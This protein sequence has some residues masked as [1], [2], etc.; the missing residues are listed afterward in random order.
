MKIKH[1]QKTTLIDFPGKIS[2]T[3][4]LYSCNFRCGFCHNPE[5]VKQ[6]TLPDI[7]K[8]EVLDFLNKRKALLEGVCFTG[9]EPLLTLE[10]GFLQKIKGM[11]YFIKLD[12]NGSFPEKMQELLQSGLIDFVSMDIKTAPDKYS[13]L[14]NSDVET[15]KIEQSIR[16]ISG[17]DINYEFRTTVLM[18]HHDEKTVQGMLEWVHGISGKISCFVLQGFKN[19]GKLMSKE[20]SKENNTTETHLKS[21]KKIT[22]PYCKNVQIRN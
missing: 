19:S 2:C 6:D 1:L 11:G 18:S 9:G 17:S 15:K 8:E 4:F 16:L 5:L 10:K 22:L 14:T 12:T 21:L 3:V 7:P 20:Y 13:A